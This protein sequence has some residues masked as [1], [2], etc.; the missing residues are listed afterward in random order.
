MLFI[1]IFAKKNGYKPKSNKAFHKEFK[2]FLSNEWDVDKARNC[3]HED[4]HEMMGVSEN[5]MTI[6]ASEYGFL[7]DKKYKVYLHSG[8]NSDSYLY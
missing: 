4:Y 1:V 7:A 8:Y 2:Q 6:L 5:R 3:N